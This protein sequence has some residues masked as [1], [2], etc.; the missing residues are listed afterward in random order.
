VVIGKSNAKYP[1]ERKTM[2]DQQLTEALDIVV[3]RTKHERYRE[4][5]ADGTVHPWYQ[6]QFQALMG[7]MATGE[8]RD[9]TDEEALATPAARRHGLTGPPRCCGGMCSV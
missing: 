5:C 2:T 7:I 9:V 3:G 1:Y 4:L 8:H 6:A